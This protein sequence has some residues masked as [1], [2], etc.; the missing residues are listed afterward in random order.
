MGVTNLF[1]ISVLQAR[2]SLGNMQ[3]TPTSL[4]TDHSPGKKGLSCEGLREHVVAE[5][6]QMSSL[7][8]FDSAFIMKALF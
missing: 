7:L 3:W 8:Q 6:L 1:L 4:I 5:F 2:G